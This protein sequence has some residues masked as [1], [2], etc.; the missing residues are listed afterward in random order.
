MSSS[1]DS[2]PRPYG[3]IP[4]D[5]RRAARRAK[6]VAAGLQMFGTRGIA[7]TRVD[8]VCAAAGLTKRYFYES[9]ASL[10][11]LVQA[12]LH[13]V[14]AELTSVVV[15]AIASGGW[16]NPRPALAAFMNALLADAR[17]VRLLVVETH[18]GALA[19]QRQQ[20]VELAVDT[21]LATDPGADKSP[22]YLPVQRLL[23][24]AMAGAAGEIALAWI[25][26]RIDLPPEA[27]VE[28][29]VR[30]FQR[31]TPGG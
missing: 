2:A 1:A 15:P 10:D 30:I 4:G 8:D 29:V 20:L 28:H 12:V 18:N 24:H 13:H 23:A 11:D 5:E 27:I 31:I 14:L 25:N 3:G 21:W 17:L 22:E 6:L 26:G 7:E 9:F 16:R 19:D